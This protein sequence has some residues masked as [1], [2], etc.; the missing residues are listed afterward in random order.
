MHDLC[1]RTV[2]GG[3]STLYP[4]PCDAWSFWP[5]GSGEKRNIE[6]AVRNEECS[7]IL[8]MICTMQ[9]MQYWCAIRKVRLNARPLLGRLSFANFSSLLDKIRDLVWL[10]HRVFI[11]CL[12]FY[13]CVTCILEFQSC[14]KI[15]LWALLSLPGHAVK[16][17]GVIG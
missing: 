4:V 9:G 5:H 11:H 8:D 14:W 10:F 16:W 2:V 12:H 7:N 17:V 13:L 6:G 1:H 3:W 15:V